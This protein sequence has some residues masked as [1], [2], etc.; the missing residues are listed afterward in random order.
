[1][2]CIEWFMIEYKTYVCVLCMER[3]NWI[4]SQFVFFVNFVV[5]F[6][7]CIIFWARR[8]HECELD[9]NNIILLIIS[10]RTCMRPYIM[11]LTIH[12]RCI[13]DWIMFY[14]RAWWDVLLKKILSC[15]SPYALRYK[16]EYYYD[17][18]MLSM[19]YGSATV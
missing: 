16:D 10:P 6:N 9:Y 14:V 1:M 11:E 13:D 17:K 4:G 19:R 3:M 2:R 18:L 5:V 8:A 12:N 7:Y 15:H